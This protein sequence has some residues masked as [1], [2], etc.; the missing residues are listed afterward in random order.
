MEEKA[1][2]T[3][4]VIGPRKKATHLYPLAYLQCLNQFLQCF[5]AGYHTNVAYNLPLHSGFKL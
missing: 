4:P 3:L 1:V 5:T 2:F